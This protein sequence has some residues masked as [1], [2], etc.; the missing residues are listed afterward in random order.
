MIKEAVKL[1]GLVSAKYVGPA[2]SP[3]LTPIDFSSWGY[4]CEIAKHEC[5]KNK[6]LICFKSGS[7]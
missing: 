6:E 5:L 2:R 4:T 7:I 1:V 3:N